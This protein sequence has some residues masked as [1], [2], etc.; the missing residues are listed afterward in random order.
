MGASTGPGWLGCTPAGALPPDRS[1]EQVVLL[2]PASRQE[3]Y[4]KEEQKNLKNE[5]LRAQEEVKRIQVGALLL[6]QGA[7][8]GAIG[9]CSM[10]AAHW[11]PLP[12]SAFWSRLCS[13]HVGVGSCCSA[14][15]CPMPH[16]L[17]AP[18]P[19]PT[20]TP[21][22]RRCRQA[23]ARTQQQ[24]CAATLMETS[25]LLWP[26]GSMWTPSPCSFDASTAVADACCC[27][28]TCLPSAGGAAG[29]WPVPGDGGQQH[30]HCGVHHGVQLLRAHPVHPQPV[31]LR[32]HGVCRGLRVGEL[33]V[34]EHR[35]IPTSCG[36]GTHS[37]KE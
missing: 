10:I 5:L 22:A 27:S 37:C 8:L 29:H 4:I 28:A 31:R 35:A 24:H 21:R 15:A 36:R 13:M 14:M 9:T 2:P 12:E 30:G 16:P 19:L 23:A 7:L 11:L 1:N 26:S 32:Q 3:E 33:R 18:Q 34:C 25:V 17:G 20:A 6:A